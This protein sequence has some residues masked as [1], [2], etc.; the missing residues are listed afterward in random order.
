MKPPYEITQSILKCYGEIKETLGQAIS[1][2]LVKPQAKLRKQNRIKTIHSSLAIEGNTLNVKQVTAIIDNKRILGPKKDIL[3]VKNAIKAYDELTKFKTYSIKDFLKAHFLLMNNL[4]QKPGEYR[5]KQVGI[6]K[7]AEVKH[8]APKYISVPGLI[9]DLFDYLKKDKDIDIIKSCVFHY[10]IEF[11]HPFEDGNGRIGRLWQIRILMD[12]N[13]L[14]E[15]VPIED[16]IKNNQQDYYRILEN[17]DNKG[18]STEFIEFM[19]NVINQTLI[20][21]ILETKAPNIDYQKRTEYAISKLRG[22][23]TRKEYMIVNKGISSATAS[24]DLKRL[25]EEGKVVS[26]GS[27]RMT[28]YSYF[29]SKGRED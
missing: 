4:I 1:L 7:G 17:C 10:E 3:E 27:G 23:F 11:I 25:L 20:N 28:L 12:V 26:K 6:V 19:L 15:Y 8:I 29:L 18:N 9:E 21:T 22:W 5:R 13:P 2:F 16:T 24:R 14:F